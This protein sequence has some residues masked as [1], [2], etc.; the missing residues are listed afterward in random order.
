MPQ[1]VR[2]RAQLIQGQPQTVRCVVGDPVQP[3]LADRE[4]DGHGREEIPVELDPSCVVGQGAD[5]DPADVAGAENRAEAFLGQIAG[6]QHEP[7]EPVAEFFGPRLGAAEQA[8]GHRAVFGPVDPVDRADVGNH[9][10]RRAAASAAQEIH[11]FRQ[12]RVGSVPEAA[13]CGEHLAL[14][15]RRDARIVAQR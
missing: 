2:P 12:M 1:R 7:L 3:G 10:G 11:Q 5:Q 14:G 8:P 9:R 4:A 13:S 15:R 6:A